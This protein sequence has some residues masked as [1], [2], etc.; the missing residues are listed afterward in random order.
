MSSHILADQLLSML[1]N[2]IEVIGAATG[3]WC[4]WLAAKEKWFNWP[5]SLLSGAMYAI[6]FYQS[7]YFSDAFLQI[8]FAGFQI[9]GWISWTRGKPNESKLEITHLSRKY[10]WLLPL[11]FI[12]VWGIWYNTLILWQPK[13][14]LPFWDSFTT[15]ISIIAIVLQARK[16]LESWYLWIL[17]DIIYIPMYI[18]KSLDLTA[19]LYLLFLGLA[20]YGL[21]TWKRILSKKIN[22]YPAQ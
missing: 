3:F 11:L 12:V 9:A 10:Y 7:G 4:V 16:I 20:V 19:L 8:I 17:V 18:Y 14:S 13:A 21:A 15:V 1:S 5:V 22:L 2:P 6:V